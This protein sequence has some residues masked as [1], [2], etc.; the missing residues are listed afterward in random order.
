MLDSTK[1]TCRNPTRNLYC[2]TTRC[3]PIANADAW[4]ETTKRNEYSYR[5]GSCM[6]T[7]T[8]L[9]DS[10]PSKSDRGSRMKHGKQRGRRSNVQP[11]GPVREY[12]IQPSIVDVS[13]LGLVVLGRAGSKGHECRT[14]L[15]NGTGPGPAI[16]TRKTR[17]CPQ[18]P[19]MLL[20]ILGYSTSRHSQSV[21]AYLPSQ[22]TPYS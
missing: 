19:P 3:V 12:C 7:V 20:P 8:S 13:H 15:V 1:F 22:S 9:T 10:Q 16:P 17:G 2:Y 11:L 14:S 5:R 4:N 18:S 6:R 21:L